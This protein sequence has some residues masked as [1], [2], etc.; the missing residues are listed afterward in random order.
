MIELLFC[1]LFVQF[2]PAVTE[3]CGYFAIDKVFLGFVGDHLLFIHQF[4]K[5]NPKPKLILSQFCLVL[6][7]G[8]LFMYFN[9]LGLFVNFHAN[10]L[11]LSQLRPLVNQ[12]EGLLNHFSVIRFGECLLFGL[13]QV[14]DLGQL[15]VLLFVGDCVNG[16]EG[17][18]RGGG[19]H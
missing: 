3:L 14:L 15:R 11:K 9:T 2:E 12:R 19:C 4:S 1:Q 17:L 13:S 8:I 16:V 6:D 7:P 18:C 5:H 10:I